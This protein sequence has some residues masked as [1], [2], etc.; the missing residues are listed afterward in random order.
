[1]SANRLTKPSA[2]MK[3]KADL[4]PGFEVFII[5]V[6]SQLHRHGEGDRYRTASG[7]DRPFGYAVVPTACACAVSRLSSRDDCVPRL[8]LPPSG[9][10]PMKDSP[11]PRAIRRLHSGPPSAKLYRESIVEFPRREMP[12][13]CLW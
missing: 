8:N 10:P 5:G 13:V 4:R 3:R 7:S 2:T 9:S 11:G 1:M 12:R 6:G